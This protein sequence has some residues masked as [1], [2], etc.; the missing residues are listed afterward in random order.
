MT[1]TNGL[2]QT[3]DAVVDE[4]ETAITRQ[5]SGGHRRPGPSGTAA[6]GEVVLQ[7]VERDGVL[8]VEE[9]H[10]YPAARYGNSNATSVSRSATVTRGI[11]FTDP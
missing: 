5:I 1:D 6:E 2:S 8:H 9:T 3:L 4:L 10:Q 11:P 7:V